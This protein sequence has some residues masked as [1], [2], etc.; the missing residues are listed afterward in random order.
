LEGVE[1]ALDKEI[2][3]QAVSGRVCRD[4]SG[5]VFLNES[6][7][8]GLVH[9]ST[10]RL[11]IDATLQAIAEAEL[12][13]QVATF[14]AAGG[15]VVVMDPRTGEILAMANA[16]AFDPNRYHDA[17]KAA[18]RNRAVTDVFE[19][20]STAKALVLAAALDA[21]VITLRDKFF[22]EDGAMRIGR[23]TIHDHHPHGTL[24]VPE[25]L[26]VSSNICS[27]KIGMMLGAER[28]REYLEAFG[29][30]RP[31]GAV[32]LVGELRGLMSAASSW[33]EVR[34]AN[35]SFGQ[36]VSVTALQLAS[37]FATLANEGVRMK[38]HVIRSVR[39]AEGTTVMA[40]E[41]EAE[42]QVVSSEIARQIS[43]ILETVVMPGGTAPSAAIDGIRVA[44]KTGTAQKVENGHYNPKKWVSSFVGYLPADAPRLVIAV[45]IDEPQKNHFG[46][47]VAAPVFKRIAEAGLDYLHIYRAPAL[48]AP[49][50]TIDA[51]V[52]PEVLPS[53]E[54]YDGK[55]PD[56]RG[57]SLRS[58]VR[59]LDGCECALRIDGRGYVVSQQPDPGSVLAPSA[60]VLLTLADARAALAR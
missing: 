1:R 55:M 5:R 3:G 58:A 21:G 13:A 52:P 23:W 19:P 27:A 46:G 22:C 54:S 20:G 4:V 2:R 51:E 28:L 53:V 24:T 9:G 8:A 48:E 16:P 59:A 11:T 36:G 34:V 37:S 25:I 35:V 29:F 56:L 15:T 32:G 10:V 17:A 30:G 31:S 7:R 26:K 47:I 39:T 57:L 38:P 33:P 12:N 6:D 42:G 45:T 18:R 41:P 43:S 49:V 44:G 40:N 50:L 14:E 60:A